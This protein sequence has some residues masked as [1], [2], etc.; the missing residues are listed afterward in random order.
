LARRTSRDEIDRLDTPGVELLQQFLWST[1]VT[2]IV[3]P[4][5]V[6]D[7]RLDR[8]RVV[9]RSEENPEAG[10]TQSEA[11]APSAAK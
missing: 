8:T 2:D 5:V 4:T 11:Q 10:L 1:Q 3:E 9:V 7:V 6:C